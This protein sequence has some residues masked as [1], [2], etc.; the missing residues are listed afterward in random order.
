MCVYILDGIAI[1][2]GRI[3]LTRNLSLGSRSDSNCST[4]IGRKIELRKRVW[5]LNCLGNNL[6]SRYNITLSFMK[7]KSAT[8]CMCV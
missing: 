7:P 1:S 2:F 6:L 3:S 5:L 8:S 4:Q